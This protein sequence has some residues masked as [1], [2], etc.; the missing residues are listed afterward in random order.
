MEALLLSTHNICFH[1]EIRKL[2]SLRVISLKKK[3]VLSE[4]MIHI[5]AILVGGEGLSCWHT[6]S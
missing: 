1:A 6:Q 4:A 3:N 2:S 5:F